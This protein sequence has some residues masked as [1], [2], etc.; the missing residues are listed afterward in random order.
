VDRFDAII[1][2][3]DCGG[4]TTAGRLLAA[5]KRVAVIARELIGGECS[6]WAQTSAA[7]GGRLRM[8]GTKG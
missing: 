1:I 4:Q 6:H 2:G 8:C 3:M 5:G 7:S